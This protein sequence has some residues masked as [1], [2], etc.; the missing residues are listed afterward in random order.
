[1]PVAGA[2]YKYVSILRKMTSHPYGSAFSGVIHYLNHILILFIQQQTLQSKVNL[3]LQSWS[4]IQNF[5][6]LSA[7][8]DCRPLAV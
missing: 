4:T 6:T 3:V 5:D 8:A 2:C 7:L 1:M